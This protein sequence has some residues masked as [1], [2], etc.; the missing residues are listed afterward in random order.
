[1]TATEITPQVSLPQARNRS[2]RGYL[3]FGTGLGVAAGERDLE[4]A[5][6]R[7]RP[8]ASKLLAAA[9]I[10][11]FR[12][13]PAAEW[14]TEFAAFLA[15][16][17]ERDLAATLL[18]PRN[19]VIVRTVALPGVAAND[20]AAAVEL[21][22]ETLHPWGDDE[23]VAF[24]WLPVGIGNALVGVVRKSILD[25]Y[26]TLFSEAGIPIAGISF[27]ASAIH[28]ALRVR[29]AGPTSLLAFDAADGGVEIYGESASRP[30]YSAGFRLPPERALAIARSELRLEP[31]FPAVTWPES[32]G[33]TGS[34]NSAAW[35]AALAAS[36]P[37]TAKYANLLPKDRRAS[38]ARRQ[39]V[40]PG[41]LAV[42]LVLALAVVFAVMPAFERRDYLT[43]LTAETKRLEPRAARA[44]ALEKNAA[45]ARG[46]ISALDNFRRRP[47][48]DLEILAELTKLLAAPVWTN[49]VEIYPDSVVVAGEAE[50]AA[51]LLKILDSS[52]LFQNSEFSLSVTRNGQLEQFRIKTMLRGRA[53]RTT[54]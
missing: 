38:S 44:Q 34:A 3:V 51:P 21:Q 40:V 41:I 15:A 7:S 9:T 31:G 6:A 22:V 35:A 32:L 19:E 28:A 18:L 4:V 49:S 50:Q 17:G 13:R 52:P 2:S 43:A 16:A 26:E 29:D 5:I 42:L 47:Q 33:L 1:M 24:A 46:R 12:T 23:Q 20:I 27:S 39:Y 48:A 25:A 14:G 45:T 30:A 11:D 54:P 36:A 8:S 37:L 10:R 53:T